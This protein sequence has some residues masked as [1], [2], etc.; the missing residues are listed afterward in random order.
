M[1]ASA[2]DNAGKTL[3]MRDVRLG[4]LDVA[5]ERRPDG[6]VYLQN[7]QPLGSYAT[8]IT[9]RMLHWALVAP[10]RIFMAERGADGEWRKLS[11]GEAL[12]QVRCVATALRAR[13]LSAERP[14]MILSGNDLDHAVLGLAALYAG[15]P[16]CRS[17]RPI[18]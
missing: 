2:R 1:D 16:M 12:A 14:L 9:D 4:S 11:Y 18:R 15:I 7:K 3:R 5:V 8:R 6:T 10:Q 13:G 17:R